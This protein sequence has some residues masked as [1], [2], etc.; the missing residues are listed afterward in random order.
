MSR[1]AFRFFAVAAG[2]VL[3]W[4]VV[5]ESG[6]RTLGK[7][8]HAR[9]SVRGIDVS[10]HQREIEWGSVA[11]E[12]FDF[13]FMKATEGID[14]VDPRF[15]QNWEGADAVGLARGAYHFFR[16]CRSGAE[17]AEHFLA[18]VPD[19]PN[20][21]PPVVDVEYTGNCGRSRNADTIR[22]E[23]SAFLDAIED[24]LGNTAIIYADSDAYRRVIS[25]HFDDHP[26]WI[27]ELSDLPDLADGRDWTFWQ[28]SHKGSV[29]GISGDV[30]MNVF[31]GSRWTFDRLVD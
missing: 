26:L 14:W 13:V 10:H 8:A 18:T 19:G 5:N 20:M 11:R 3:A 12:G 1:F 25:G 29:D 15:Q 6:L 23:L 16:F 17:Q 7:P 24:A 27:P 31:A 30:D 28:Y 22:E 21:L 4:V 2:L 9:Y